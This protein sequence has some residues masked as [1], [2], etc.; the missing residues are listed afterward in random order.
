M[1]L[2][3]DLGFLTMDQTLQT[4]GSGSLTHLEVIHVEVE[5]TSMQECIYYLLAKRVKQGGKQKKL[6]HRPNNLYS[7]MPNDHGHFDE[8]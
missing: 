8:V 3:P 6:P 2:E 5:G 1:I 4:T 7:N